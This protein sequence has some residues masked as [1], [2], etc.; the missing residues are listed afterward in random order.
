[1]SNGASKNRKQMLVVSL[2]ITRLCV[3]RNIEVVKRFQ[4]P[5]QLRMFKICWYVNINNQVA[6]NTDIFKS[7]KF[8]LFYFYEQLK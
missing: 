5:T 1:M 4:T 6:N 2:V 7:R 3:R 8:L